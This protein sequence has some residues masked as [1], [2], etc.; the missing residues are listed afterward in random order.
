[1]TIVFF[2]T[3]TR[4]TGDSPLVSL[5]YAKEIPRG[6]MLIYNRVMD[7]HSPDIITDDIDYL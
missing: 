5:V 2:D 6:R 3:E 4:L 7:L 1:M